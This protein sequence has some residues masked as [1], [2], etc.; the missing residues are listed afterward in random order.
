MEYL[1][2]IDQAISSLG[3]PTLND[4]DAFDAF[5]HWMCDRRLGGY[6]REHRTIEADDDEAEEEA[7]A[8]PRFED[9][10]EPGTHWE[11]IYYIVKIG[12]LLQYKTY[13]A[14]PSREAFAKKLGDLATL[15]SVPPILSTAP[16]VFRVDAIWYKP[17]P[18]IFLF[19]VEDGGTMREALHRLYNAMA[20]DARF[21]V[22]GPSQNL[23]KYQKW[24]GT[25]P[26]KE[27]EQRYQWRT[28][29]EHFAF[30]GQATDFTLMRS[31]F[32]RI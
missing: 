23:E 22:I 16:E 26:F 20:F 15:S 8:T 13:V 6:A 14:D 11:A 1:A 24:V 9:G 17:T 31:R 7:E 30:F 27:F 3:N 2:V 18:P 28:Y 21:F 29:S 12:E 10:T 5:C 4:V 32:L 19:E 25:A